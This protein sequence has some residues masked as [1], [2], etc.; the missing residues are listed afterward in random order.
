MEWMTIKE[1]A[2]YLRVSFSTI[3]KYV[4]TGKLP[5]YQQEHLIRLKQSDLDAFLAP[6]PVKDQKT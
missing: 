5:S 4:K 2:K 1:T 6:S 3:R